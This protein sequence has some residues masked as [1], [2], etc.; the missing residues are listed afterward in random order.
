MNPI[1]LPPAASWGIGGNLPW[2][3]QGGGAGAFGAD[4]PGA[5]GQAYQGAYNSSLGMNESMYNNIMKGYQQ[6]IQSQTTAQQAISAGYTNLYNSVLGNVEQQYAGQDTQLKNQAAQNL[7]SSS[8]Q[9]VDRGL[10]NTTIQTSVNQG[11][12]NQLAQQQQLL[13]GQKAGQLAQTQS[14][15]GLAGLSAQQ[16]GLRDTTGLAL[17]QLGFMNSME[18][19]YP[20]G[21][22]YAKLAQQAGQ[23]K[24][25]RNN[26]M[27]GAGGF[28]GANGHPGPQLGYVPSN[29][30]YGSGGTGDYGG[31]SFG[32]ASS[33]AALSS[34]NSGFSGS[35]YGDWSNGPSGAMSAAMGAGYGASGYGSTAAEATA[36]GAAY[37]AVGAMDDWGW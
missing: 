6:A 19:A 11:V 29:P 24:A 5:V 34:Q 12:N 30:Y 14:Q 9:L 18:A 13:T 15:L 31:G 8:Q 23:N 26:P 28:G 10:G 25:M 17:S 7:A 16:S 4:S 27:G 32:G 21:D 36:A 1:G 37:G 35:G 20:N 3:S 2:N 22:M 33:L